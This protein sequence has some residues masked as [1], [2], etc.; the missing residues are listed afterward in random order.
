MAAFVT[1]TFVFF[2]FF[3]PMCQ[4][5]ISRQTAIWFSAAVAGTICVLQA[6]KIRVPLT[7]VNEVKDSRRAYDSF[8]YVSCNVPYLTVVYSSLEYDYT[9][10]NEYVYVPRLRS[11]T[12]LQPTTK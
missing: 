7:H 4:T 5:S 12:L 1:V 6:G 2:I 8:G 3:P 11:N 9:V 10:L